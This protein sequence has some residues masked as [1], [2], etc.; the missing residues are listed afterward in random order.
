ATPSRTVPLC[1][2]PNLAKP[3]HDY[4]RTVTSSIRSVVLTSRP[5][6]VVIAVSPVCLGITGRF[7]PKPARAD[8]LQVKFAVEIG[9]DLGPGPRG[10]AT[11]GSGSAY[12]ESIS[13]RTACLSRVSTRRDC[14]RGDWRADG[15]IVAV[16]L[17]VEQDSGALID[18]AGNAF[19]AHGDF[20]I[21]EVRNVLGD[22]IGEIR[23]GLNP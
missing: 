1:A 10:H 17:E 7:V 3:C 13:P 9:R 4:R 2:L 8:M 19:E 5:R 16:R 22:D 12:C 21:A 23:I 14:F 20:A 6:Q 11:D 18:A 15:E